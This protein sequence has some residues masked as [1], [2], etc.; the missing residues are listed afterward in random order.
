MPL[1]LTASA[2]VAQTGTQE[3][4]MKTLIFSNEQIEDAM[5]IVI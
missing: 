2:S 4:G 3:L 1:G 5:K